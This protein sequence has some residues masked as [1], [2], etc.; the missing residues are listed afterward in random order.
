[1]SDNIENRHRHF[2]MD[3]H[4]EHDMSNMTK[5]GQKHFEVDCHVDHVTK[6]YHKDFEMDCDMDHVIKKMILL[7]TWIMIYDMWQN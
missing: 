3:C 6:N 7:L 4:M 5:N 2:E 1:V